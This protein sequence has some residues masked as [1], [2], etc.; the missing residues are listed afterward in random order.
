VIGSNSVYHVRAST[1]SDVANTAVAAG[2]LVQSRNLL[3]DYNLNGRGLHFTE[4]R[5]RMRKGSS[6][7]PFF[8]SSL[9]INYRLFSGTQQYLTSLYMIS[10]LGMG[11]KIQTLMGVMI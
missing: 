9:Q 10:G 1:C 2:G 3:S 11:T 4:C 5:S 6:S 7:N 8:R